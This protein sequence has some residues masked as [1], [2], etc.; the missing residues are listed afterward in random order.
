VSECWALALGGTRRA[1]I[2]QGGTLR[3]ADDLDAYFRWVEAEQLNLLD[4]LYA[5]G[6][7]TILTV[8]RLP[9]DRGASYSLFAR[10]AVGAVLD[11]PNR[12]A[13][14]ARRDL[15]VAVAGDPGELATAIDD[16]TV[17]DRCAALHNETSHGRGGQLIYLFRGSWA[18]GAEEARWGYR[19][20]RTLGRV[21]TTA[22]L[23]AGYYGMPV[24]PLT[25][26]IGSGRTRIAHLRPPFLGGGEDCYWS[27]NC[28]LRLS[29]DDWARILEDHL[30]ARRTVSARDYP[31]DPVARQS[32]AT[33]ISALDHHILGL[34]RLHSLGFWAPA[35]TVPPVCG[36]ERV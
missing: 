24:P 6:I 10:R 17:V 1:Y 30:H 36:E 20:G 19:I 8:G 29:G 33:A 13:F 11:S 31:A 15:R 4:R 32:L 16:S 14:Y 23:I 26:Y 12:R 2:A 21:P 25:V 35:T 5:L 18:D 7:S 3:S 34:G 22:D 9:H 27:A 28:P